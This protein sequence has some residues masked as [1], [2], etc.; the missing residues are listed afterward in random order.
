MANLILV[1]SSKQILTIIIGK[2]TCFNSSYRMAVTKAKYQLLFQICS[3]QGQIYISLI[4]V[5]YKPNLKPEIKFDG[6]YAFDLAVG[7][8][9]TPKPSS[10]S[11]TVFLT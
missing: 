5:L 10:V 1:T 3:V 2:K 11:R 6:F 8:L 4:Q 9:K 7:K